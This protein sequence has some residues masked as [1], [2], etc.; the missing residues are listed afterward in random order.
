M[1]Y[2]CG[3]FVIMNGKT[4]D[5]GEDLGNS[6]KSVISNLTALPPGMP[7]DARS[8]GTSPASVTRLADE[9]AL[10][11]VRGFWHTGPRPRN[12]SFVNVMAG[13]TLRPAEPISGGSRDEAYVLLKWLVVRRAN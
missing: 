13:G 6:R 3:S 7:R 11:G 9:E 4:G 12:C 5:S 2:A 8:A 1:L 10:N